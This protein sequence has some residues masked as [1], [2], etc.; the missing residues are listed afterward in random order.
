MP[1]EKR[2]QSI[3]QITKQIRIQ[4]NVV[5][6]EKEPPSVQGRSSQHD[7]SQN[8]SECSPIQKKLDMHRASGN[9]TM[10]PHDIL[11]NQ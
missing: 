3:E 6:E 9:E 2:D 8:M 5:E 4:D 11:K 10:L 7:S 1:V